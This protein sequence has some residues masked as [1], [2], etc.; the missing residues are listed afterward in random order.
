M[1]QKSSEADVRQNGKE[2]DEPIRAQGT[3]GTTSSECSVRENTGLRVVKT[4][5]V[6]LI[7]WCNMLGNPGKVMVLQ[8]SR[9]DG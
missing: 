9:A 8:S 5:V 3:A 1:N 4:C 2:R 7:L 6:V